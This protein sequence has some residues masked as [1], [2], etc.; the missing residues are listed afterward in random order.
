LP[1]Q[2]P[3]VE[4]SGVVYGSVRVVASSG[5]AHASAGLDTHLSIR[6]GRLRGTVR[7]L[8]QAPIAELTLFATDGDTIQKADLATLLRPG[9]TL[10]VDVPVQAEATPAAS[11]SQRVLRSTALAVLASGG[12]PVLTG[13]TAPARSSLSVDGQL[14][15]QNGVAILQQAVRLG[16]ADDLLR[17]FE[18]KRLASSSGE[19]GAGFQDAYD[20]ML[21]DTS[22][23]L[24]L[25]FNHDLS[26]Q[27]EVY[28]FSQS[29]FLAVQSDST[30]VLV[31]V[32]LSPSQ[33]SAGMVRV[34]FRE[35]R[36]FQGSGLWVD[37]AD[38]ANP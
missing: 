3:S 1:G 21:P 26:G 5:V 16:T 38:A 24:K 10:E 32:P 20:V 13:L 6:G 14:P 15:P 27:F 2:Q 18:Q 8:S 37:V 9:R 31:S 17:Y 11:A 22:K 12:G 36:L 4:E 29:R 19:A 23:P 34:R 30:D 25:I 35:A 28:D 33:V 7:N